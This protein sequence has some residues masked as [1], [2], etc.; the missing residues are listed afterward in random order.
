MSQFR[1]IEF[2]KSPKTSYTLLPF[3]FTELDGNR[4]VVTNLAG[5]YLLAQRQKLYDLLQHNLS[6]EDPMYVELR[7]RH[8]LID[9]TTSIAPE[10]LAIKLRTRYARL[11]EFTGLHMFVVTLRCEHSCHYCQVSRQ[12]EDKVK[13]DMTSETASKAVD[14]ALRSPSQN[15]KFEFQ[16]GEPLL[17]FA[18]IKFIVLE[19]KNRN[20]A[21]GKNLAFVIATNLALVNQ[22][23]LRFCEEHSILISTSLDGP[24]DLHNT[25][26]PRPGGNSYEK[27][28]EGIKLARHILGRDQVS[29]LMTTTEGSLNRVREII[30]EYLAQEFTGI[31]LRPLSPYG[32][33]IRTKSYKAYSAERW[34]NFYKEGLEYIIDLNRQGINLMEYYASTI[35]KKMLTSDDPGYVDLMSPAGIGIGAVVYNYDAC[36]YASDEGRMLAEMGVEKFKLGNVLENSYEEIFT[37][38]NLLDPLEESF[39]YSAPMCNDCAFES[40]CGADPV[41]HYAVSKDYLGRKPDSE[42][43]SRNMEIFR[44]LIKKMED[45]KFI[46]QLFTRWANS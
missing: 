41:F 7:S 3:R 34:L 21:L 5:E 2:Y 38:P 20:Q 31:F 15:I 8:F 12:S 23:I 26:R 28:I 27:T 44:F 16:G 37:S 25:N 39:A 11:A 6:N 35:L 42:F 9:D 14:L 33:A 22:E 45:E 17:N 19:A 43:C 1:P 40:Y 13:F 18:L 36:V 29:A 10:L 4:Y 32:F 30:D 24:K 46:H